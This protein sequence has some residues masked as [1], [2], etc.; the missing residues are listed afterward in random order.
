MR[1]DANSRISDASASDANGPSKHHVIERDLSFELTGVFFEIHNA[2]GRFCHE[3]QYSDAITVALTTKR[4]PFER[5]KVLDPMFP[6]EPPG[7][8]RVDFLVDRRILIEVKAKP[9]V[10]RI[11]YVQVHRYL[12][13]LQLKLG[14][15]VNF[16]TKLVVPRRILN[17]QIV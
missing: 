10:E 6:G 4:I 16:G 11:D 13:A 1:M 7:R 2:L 3:R 8:H 5:E 17:S 12:A 9:A 15:L 14:L